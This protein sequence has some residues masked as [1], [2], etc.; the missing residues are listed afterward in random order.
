MDST[1]GEH[2]DNEKPFYLL[3]KNKMLTL[4]SPA[5]EIPVCPLRSSAC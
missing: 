1:I 3:R 4:R 2:S 5:A